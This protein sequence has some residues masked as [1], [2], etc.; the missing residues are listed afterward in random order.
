MDAN[1]NY[2]MP[3]PTWAGYGNVVAAVVDMETGVTCVLLGVVSLAVYVGGE[4]RYGHVKDLF[5]VVTR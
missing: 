1:P 4:H 3:A 2:A 5:C